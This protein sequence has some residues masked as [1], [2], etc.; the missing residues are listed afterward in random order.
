MTNFKITAVLILAFLFSSCS[1]IDNLKEKLGGKSEGDKEEV[2]KEET[3]GTTS[4]NDLLFYNKYIEVLNKVSET[5]EQFHKAYLNDVPEPK[6][7]DKNSMIFVISTDVYSGN[8]ERVYKDYKRS[9]YDNGELAQLK[10]DNE[11][12]KSEVEE[13]FK[14]VLFILEEYY[15]LAREVIDYYKNKDFEQN[16]ALAITYDDRMKEEYNK[17]KDAFDKLNNVVRKY[18]PLKTMLDPDKISDP[19]KKAV[20][21]L[22]ITYENTLDGAEVFFQELQKTDKNS[23]VTNLSKA[24]DEFEKKFN[25]DKA[26]VNLTGFTEK[27]KYMK[28]SFEDYFSKTVKDF[29]KETRKFIDNVK[30]K[31]QDSDGFNRSYDNV[32][33]YYNNMINA[34]NSSIGVLNTYEAF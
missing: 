6:T 30:T 8:I 26:R 10:V 5:V 32:I 14:V 28:Y 27:T 4:Q 33:T 15:N 17:F 22:M 20:T 29:V 1:L 24:L 9:L 3:A 7:I 34:Y 25:E 13:N 19:D 12:M 21:I 11:S 16:A 23:D 2:K 18:K 31:K